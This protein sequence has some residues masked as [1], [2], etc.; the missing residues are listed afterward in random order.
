[1]DVEIKKKRIKH[2]ILSI[3]PNG[4]VV[5]SAPLYASNKSINEFLKM[6]EDWLKEHYDKALD[7][8]L[9]YQICDG[10]TIYLIGNP[11]IFRIVISDTEEV[12]FDGSFLIIKVKE[13]DNE[14]IEKV[15]N[16]FLNNYRKEIYNNALNKYLDLTHETI[17]E[18]KIKDLKRA[19]GKCY[20]KARVIELS[21]SIIHKP[22]DFIEAICMH[23][24]AHL[25]YPNHQKEFYDYI[26]LY[27]K[28]YKTRVKH[29][30]NE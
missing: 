2:F 9:I 13:N 5:L 21:K 30:I 4:A 10:S 6:N 26:Y 14:R 12:S 24:I 20:Y 8:T 11:Y 22:I 25:K 16:K 29:L 7:K 15:F 3:K 1:M 17:S 18:L 23:E 28:D 27:M 19:N